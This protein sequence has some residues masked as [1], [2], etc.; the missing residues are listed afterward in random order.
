M[1]LHHSENH[2]A[3]GNKTGS[4]H[5]SQEMFYEDLITFS[6]QLLHKSLPPS[7]QVRAII[8]HQ[9]EHNQQEQRKRKKV[10]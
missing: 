8:L 9:G 3:E 10:G 7:Y 5:F 2:R 6:P 4:G 1:I